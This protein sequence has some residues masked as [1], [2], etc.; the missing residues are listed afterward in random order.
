MSRAKLFEQGWQ[1]NERLV[2]VGKG[3]TACPIFAQ[4][5]LVFL[6]EFFLGLSQGA[7]GTP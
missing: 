1:R 5:K 3:G 2:F 6:M 7:R 4:A